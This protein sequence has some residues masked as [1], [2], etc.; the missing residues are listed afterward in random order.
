MLG[1]LNLRFYALYQ[2]ALHSE[3]LDAGDRFELPMHLAYE[4]GV[5]TNPTRVIYKYISFSRTVPVLYAGCE[6]YL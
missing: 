4:T 6:I 1:V 5:V 2:A 3:Y